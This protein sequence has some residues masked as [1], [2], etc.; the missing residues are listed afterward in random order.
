MIATRCF[1]F[2]TQAR[3]GKTPASRDQSEFVCYEINNAILGIDKTQRI[4]FLMKA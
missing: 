1:K 2:S 4:V 3:K